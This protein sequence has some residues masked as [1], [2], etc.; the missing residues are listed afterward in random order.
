MNNITRINQYTLDFSRNSGGSCIDEEHLCS[1]MTDVCTSEYENIV[2]VRYKDIWYLVIE[3]YAD[4]QAVNDGK[5]ETVGENI[6][7]G[8]EKMY[9]A[10]CPY[11]GVDLGGKKII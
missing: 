8:I 5:A 7:E 1:K 6:T 4:E 9:I 10:F 11:C 2:V 3:K